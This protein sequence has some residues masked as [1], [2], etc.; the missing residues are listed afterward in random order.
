MLK[1]N[2][3]FFLIPVYTPD[4]RLIIYKPVFLSIASLDLINQER[5]WGA[6]TN[7]RLQKWTNCYFNIRGNESPKQTRYINK[8]T[9]LASSNHNEKENNFSCL[10][11]LVNESPVRKKKLK[12][13]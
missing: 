7:S 2:H 10:Y 13:I 11:L 1:P 8:I 9:A 3:E 4:F 6:T 12:T 5:S